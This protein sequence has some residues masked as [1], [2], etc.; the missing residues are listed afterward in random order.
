MMNPISP[1]LPGSK[2]YE[3][4]LAKD[5]KQYI[6]LPALYFED[7]IG[8]IITRWQFTQEERDA[9]AAGADLLFSQLTFGE[10]FQPVQFQIEPAVQEED[11]P[12]VPE[13]RAISQEEYEASSAGDEGRP[14]DL[15]SADEGRARR[16]RAA[17]RRDVA[18]AGENVL[19]VQEKTVQGDDDLRARRGTRAW[20]R[21]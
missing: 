16:V 18:P 2:P 15:Q 4:I 9:I 21:P 5:Q 1:V 14:G 11:A 20:R 3:F 12:S 8:R 7:P 6:S 19:P 10:K 17:Q 13:T